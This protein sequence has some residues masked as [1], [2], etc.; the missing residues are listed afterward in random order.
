MVIVVG[1]LVSIA[2]AA[3]SELIYS[4][5][6]GLAKAMLGRTSTTAILQNSRQS[7]QRICRDGVM[8]VIELEK[9]RR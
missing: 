8:L 3:G 4:A 2:F 5:C 1:A 6:A 7:I 9:S